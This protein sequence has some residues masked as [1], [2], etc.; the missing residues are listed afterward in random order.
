VK[1]YSTKTWNNPGLSCAFRQWRADSHCQK[2]HGYDVGFKY[3]WGAD[4]LDENNWVVDFGL[5][6]DLKKIL[7]YWYDHTTIVAQDDPEI[8]WY[9]EAFSRGIIDLRIMRDVGCEKFADHA[10]FHGERWTKKVYGDRVKLISAEVFEHAGNS[11]VRLN[12]G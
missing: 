12:N 3:V 1:F 10:F 8:G 11:A 2:I 7:E 9:Q 5:A 6:K 4:V